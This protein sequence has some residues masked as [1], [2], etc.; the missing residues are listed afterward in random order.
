VLLLGWRPHDEVLALM[1]RADAFVLP[2]APE[3]FGLVYAEALAQGAPVVACRDEGPADF[4][5]DGDSGLLVPPGD[6]AAVAAAVARLLD[7]RDEAA[8][9]T[10]AGRRV[11]GELTW[12]RNATRQLEIYEEVA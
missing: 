3:G 4:V 1:A 6:E 5:V 2:S 8:R 9:L 11:V 12:R 10:A 7:D